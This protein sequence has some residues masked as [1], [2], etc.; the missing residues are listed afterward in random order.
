MEPHGR[1]LMPTLN[2]KLLVYLVVATLV[3][4]VGLFVLNYVQS[5]RATDA[6]RWQSEH[7]A[8]MNRL[9]K[10]IFYMKQYLELR[11]SDHD[12]AMK[13]RRIDIGA[14]RHPQ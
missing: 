9:D 2:R 6:L 7:A 3:F 1:A 10:A 12:A 13:L 8:E 4:G 11:P 14:R 5:D